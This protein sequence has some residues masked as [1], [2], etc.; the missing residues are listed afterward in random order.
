MLP[1]VCLSYGSLA[2]YAR[3]SRANLLEALSSDFVQSA[4][5]RGI[6]EGRLLW[7]HA[8]ANA[9][10][11]FL[12]LTGLLLPTLVS[13]SVIIERIFAWPGLGSLLF[14]SLFTRDYPTILGLTCLSAVL[15]LAGMLAADLLYLVAD[16]RLRR[17]GVRE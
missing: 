9:W 13:G 11:P 16:P 6:G 17:P 14:D 4:R 3:F 5:S 10:I 2:F 8:L 1:I 12:T 7:R 15:V